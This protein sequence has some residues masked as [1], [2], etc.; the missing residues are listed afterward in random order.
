[1][2][3]FL[4]GVLVGGAA[5]GIVGGVDRVHSATTRPRTASAAS[6]RCMLK[7]PVLGDVLLKGAVARFTRTLGTLIASGV[8]ILAGPRDHGPHRGQQGHRRSH[9]DAPAPRSARA[10]PWRRRSR[11]SGVFPPM[12]VQMISVG[13]QTG[14]LDEMLTKIAVFYEAEVDTAVDTLT[15]II[16]PVMIVVMGGIVGGMVVAMYL[17]MF[18]LITVVAG[19]NELMSAAFGSPRAG[20]AARAKPARVDGR[21]GR[22][23]ARWCAAR[24]LV[25]ALALPSGVLLRPDADVR[26]AGRCWA[27]RCSRPG[28]A[29]GAVRSAAAS[30]A[31]PARV[32]TYVQLAGGPRAGHLAVRRSP[33]GATASSCCSSRWSSITGGVLARN[34]GRARHRGRRRAIG[35][36]CALPAIGAAAARR[37]RAG[38]RR[39]DARRPGCV[40]A[41][42]A[43]ASGVLAGVAR[44]PRPAHARR[45]RAHGAR[46]RPRAARQ[47][48]DPAPPDQRRAHAWTTHGSWCYLNPAAEQVLGA[49]RARG[50]RAAVART[51]CRSG[52]GRCA[53][54]CSTRCARPARRARAPKLML[55]PADGRALPRRVLDQRARCTRAAC[56]GVVAVFQDLTDVREMERARAPQRDARRDRR[57]R[58]RHRARAAQRPQPDQRLGRV[59]AARIAARGRERACSWS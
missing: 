14:A 24:L 30:A 54:A 26:R 27:G 4:T 32:Q 45:S 55:R 9:H 49:P 59:P 17:P 19:G 8:P 18:K 47:R 38:R 20:A 31:R 5:G 29:L 34:A 48:R 23:C 58:G 35:A 52:C 28:G 25:A 11:Q 33:A 40:I 36:C 21:A 41:F 7:I 1:M 3:H 37:A 46:A 13:E 56:T 15:S 57:A 50:A 53:S 43:R 44:R 12:V 51:C 22:A 42:L 6:T 16:E 39:R 10:R 2:S